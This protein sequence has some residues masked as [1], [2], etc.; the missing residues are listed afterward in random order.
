MNVPEIDEI[1]ISR[2]FSVINKAKMT[3]VNTSPTLVVEKLCFYSVGVCLDAFRADC[4]AK[5]ATW[6]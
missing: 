4:L 5:S 2:V 6:P 3:S 1:I